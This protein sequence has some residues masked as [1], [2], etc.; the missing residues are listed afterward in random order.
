MIHFQITTGTGVPSYRQLKDQVM[1][2]VAGGTLR[3]GDALPSIRE[4]ASR[5]AVNPSTIVKAYSEL[6]HDGVIELRQGK[7]A[8][9]S[10][11]SRKISPAEMKRTLRSQARK[12]AVEAKQMGMTRQLAIDLLE[13]EMEALEKG[14]GEE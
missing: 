4:L 1:Y 6:S 13:E 12:L 5:L 8:F 10:N 3:A 2:Y 11:G 9:I 14:T 7:G